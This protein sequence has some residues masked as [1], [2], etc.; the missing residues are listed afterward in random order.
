[1]KS[2][3]RFLVAASGF[4][5]MFF[6]M[7]L[8]VLAAEAAEPDP[9]ESSTGLIFRWLNF[10]LVFGG[11][12]YL[13]AKHGGAFFSSNAKAIAASIHEATAAKA[14]A[15]RVLSEVDA[16][17]ARLDQE[18]AEMREAARRN[19]DAE[20]ERLRVSGLAEIEK[21]NQAARAELAA[22]GRVAQQQLREIT[23]SMAIEQAGKLIDSRMN[24]EVRARLFH[25]FLGELGRSTN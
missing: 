17:I 25:S 16:K 7:A 22:S 1:M 12:A 2:L 10:V 19:S 9:A 23:A 18:I 4:F 3:R 8:P 14:E 13:L 24:N 5:V 20:S 21:I 11:I 6:F 15:D